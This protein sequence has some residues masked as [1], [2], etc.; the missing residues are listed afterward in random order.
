MAEFTKLADKWR[1]KLNNRNQ[2]KKT[3]RRENISDVRNPFPGFKKKKEKTGSGKNQSMSPLSLSVSITM[4]QLTPLSL[5]TA[6]TVFNMHT[7][8]LRLILH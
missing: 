4:Q 2:Q 1:A 8:H 7:L 5:Y 3:Q 6:G